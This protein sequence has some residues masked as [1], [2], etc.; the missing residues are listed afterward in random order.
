MNINNIPNIQ[1]ATEQSGQLHDF[2]WVWHA[3]EL[4]GCSV[5]N[6]YRKS[7]VGGSGC[8]FEN[9]QTTSERQL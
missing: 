4:R 9:I 2:T 3:H 6:F 7:S 8:T 5:L 1:Y